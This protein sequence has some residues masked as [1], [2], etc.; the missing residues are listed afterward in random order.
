MAR[1]DTATNA[2]PLHG[3][4]WH[5]I[6]THATPRHNTR[7]QSKAENDTPAPAG[8]RTA[9]HGKTRHA[10]ERHGTAPNGIAHATK[11][12]PR[13][14]KAGKTRANMRTPKH[15]A[16]LSTTQRRRPCPTIKENTE[17]TCPQVTTTRK[18]LHGV[19]RQGKRSRC[20]KRNNKT[21]PQSA[22]SLGQRR[23]RSSPH[24]KKQW[25]SKL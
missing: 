19:R 24:Q 25:S 11:G 10:M 23:S 2:T 16:A 15:N 1:H 4:V 3:T 5:S 13:H 17:H 9:C 8:R 18:T 6:A 12:A 21:L 22:Q 20:S 7:R 14:D